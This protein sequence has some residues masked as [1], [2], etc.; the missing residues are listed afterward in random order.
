MTI[1]HTNRSKK[2][3][4]KYKVGRITESTYMTIG[5]ENQ[6]KEKLHFQQ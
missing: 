6:C 5:T 4:D 3:K 2:T 1:T